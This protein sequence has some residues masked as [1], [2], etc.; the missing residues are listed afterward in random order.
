MREYGC[1]RDE[2]QKTFAGRSGLSHETRLAHQLGRRAGNERKWGRRARPRERLLHARHDARHKTKCRGDAVGRGEKRRQVGTGGHGCPCV[3][4]IGFASP[5]QCS[6]PGE[7][8]GGSFG[9]APIFDVAARIAAGSIA[10]GCFR[11]P[12]TQLLPWNA[13]WSERPAAAHADRE[14]QHDGAALLPEPV[15]DDRWRRPSPLTERSSAALRQARI[16]CPAPPAMIGAETPARR[17]RPSEGS[18]IW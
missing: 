10:R 2:R 1:T 3:G 9:R 12:S 13:A 8:S 4:T 18:W 17:H 16:V 14:Q 7:N 5:L 6:S 15:A 11:T